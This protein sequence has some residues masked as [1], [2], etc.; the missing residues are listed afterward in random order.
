MVDGNTSVFSGWKHLS[1][2][3]LGVS[4]WG[5]WHNKA[6]WSFLQVGDQERAFL[7]FL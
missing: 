7:E 5:L 1:V 2:H 4:R 3:W 6:S